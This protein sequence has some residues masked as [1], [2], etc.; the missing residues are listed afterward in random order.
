MNDILYRSRQCGTVL[1]FTLILLMVV[2][3]LSLASM[4]AA[5][6]GTILSGNYQWA[7]VAFNE[8][9]L[10]ITDGESDI[11]TNFSGV[12]S[13]DWSAVQGDGLYNEGELTD[14]FG[15]WGTN[16][17]HQTSSDNHEYVLEYLGA[18]TPDGASVTF[19][20]TSNRRFMYRVTGGSNSSRGANSVI[21]TIFA[22]TD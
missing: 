1:V 22:T 7:M 11:T 6:V 2:T 19:G 12:P 17:G 3:M 16:G 5:R 20:N 18:F 13:F 8:A 14:F 15:I 10:G 9:E 4:N 21:Q